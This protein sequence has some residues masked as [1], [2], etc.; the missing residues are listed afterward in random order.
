ML[1]ADYLIV[2]SGAVGMAFADVLLTETDASII[3]VDKYAK[4]GG[5][6]NVAYPFVTLHQP[7]LYYGV[8][9]K[10]LNKG[11]KDEVGL[12]KGLHEL[13]TGAEIMAYYQDV[14]LH[15][16]LPSGRVQYFP[17]CEYKGNNSFTSLL[18]GEEH[19]VEVKKKIVD[20]TYLNTSVPSTHTPNFTIGEGVS[21]MPLNDLPKISTPPTGFVVIGGGKTGIDACLWLLENKVDPDK[22]TWI[23]SRDAWLLNRKNVQPTEEFFEASMGAQ[24]DQMEA[25]ALAT[26]I[27]DMYDRLEASGVVLRIDTS[28]RPQMFHGATISELELEQL[29]RIKHVVRKG[30]VQRIE[31]NEIIL[32]KGSIATSP[33]H[34]HVDCSASAIKNLEVAPV[35]ADNVITPQTVRP[36]QPIFSAAFIAYVELNFSDEKTKNDLCRVVPLPNH[37]TDWVRMMEGMME[38]QM[39][40]SKH[41]GI[42]KWLYNNRLDGF[43]KL[44]RDTPKDDEKKQAILKRLRKHSLPALMNLQ[45]FIKELDNAPK[46][47]FERPQ[48]QI[49]K[50]LFFKG[51]LVETPEED[52]KIEEDEILVKVDKFAFT[53]NNITYAVAGDQ[54][55]YWQFFPPAGEDTG[56][57]GIIPVWGFADVVESQ[58]PEIPVGDRLFGYFPPASHLKMKPTKISGGQF[59]ENSAH[60]AKLPKGYNFYTRV[61][62]D[63]SY[64]PATDNGRALF[65]PLFLTSFCI[66]DSLQDKGWH[67][68]KQVLILS[69]SSKT[70]IGLAYALD[71]DETAPKV[72]GITSARNLEMV[73]SLNLYDEAFAYDEIAELD[74]D[75]PTVIVDM[76]GNAKILA[77]LHQNFGDNMRYTINVGV[78]HWSQAKPP[79]GMVSERSEFFFAPGH[80]QKRIKDWGHAE[81]NQKT[82]AFMMES[83]QKT[84]SWLTYRKVDG[85]QEMAE[86]HEAVCNGKIPANEGLIVEL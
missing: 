85:L 31:K 63:P 26:S 76:S 86:L 53:A 50:N 27:D 9:S 30:K 25:A 73:K 59:L 37:D 82:T 22:I 21:F 36:Y 77:Q 49:R 60:R 69:A 19:K 55:G 71:A 47:D 33:D 52:L 42:R 29:R 38:N 66:W 12:N 83:I 64:H 58:V 17:L 6:W 54:L 5:H 81:F 20:A 48:F 68:A 18:T 70:S 40:W 45:K 79:K 3:I 2:G 10:E 13:A 34:I 4:P 61:K 75:I 57:W 41:K 78:T 1:E 24:A 15:Q 74:T 65:S 43:S 56:G 72:I 46:Q 7:S 32:E 84:A 39:T 67:S 35:F 23:V 14:M 44:V 16:F 62:A 28:V 51:R 11:R 80:I 8:S